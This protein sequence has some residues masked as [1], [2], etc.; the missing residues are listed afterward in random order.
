MGHMLN[1]T[2]QDILIRKARLQGFNSCWI[3]GTDHASIGRLRIRY[4]DGPVLE[5]EYKSFVGMHPIPIVHGMTIG[6][7]AKM[8]IGEKWIDKT[9]DLEVIPLKN[10]DRSLWFDETNINWVKP[11]LDLMQVWKP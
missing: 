8:I 9:P 6:E 11:S 5:K 10:W 4:I 7:Y 1:N 3:P 2:I